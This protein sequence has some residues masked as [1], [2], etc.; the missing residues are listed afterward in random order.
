MNFTDDV[1]L[2]GINKIVKPKK[3]PRNIGTNINANGIKNLKLPSNVKE[4]V[5]HDIPLK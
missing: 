1:L 3:R 5:I 2:L 4:L